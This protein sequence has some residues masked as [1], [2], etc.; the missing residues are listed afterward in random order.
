MNRNCSLPPGSLVWAYCR[1]SGGEDQD[2]QTQRQA[3]LDYI[4]EHDLVLDRLFVD[5]AAPGSTVVGRDAFEEMIHL[6]RTASRRVDGLVLWSFSRFARNLLDA[7]FYKADLRRKGYV[8]ISMTDDLPG[9][10]FDPIMETLYDWMHEQY[11][12]DLSRNVKRTLH[13]LARQGFSARGF[14]P[15]GYRAEKVQIGMKRNGKPRYASRWVPD[16]RWAPIVKRAFEMKADGATTKQI[17]DETRIFNTNNSLT[18]FFR[19]KTYIGVRKCGDIEVPGAHEPLVSRETWD[20]VQARLSAHARWSSSKKWTTGTHPRQRVSSYLLS[21]LIR[22]SECGSAMIGSYDRLR[23]GNKFRFYVCGKRK[24]EGIRGCHTGK[25]RA[26]LI[27]GAAMQHVMDRILTTGYVQTLLEAVNRRMNG[28][29]G[30]IDTEIARVARR[31]SDVNRAIYNLLNS[32]E[33][34][35]SAAARQR[36]TE[37]EAEK[38]QLGGELRSLTARRAES[39]LEVSDEVLSDAL[40]QMRDDLTTGE[41][42]DRRAVLGRFVHRIEAHRERATLWYTF[43]LAM[44][45]LYE[46]PQGG[47]I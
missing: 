32:V 9:G 24:R 46:C 41:L 30:R 38:A 45:P 16:P 14:P 3:V 8:I 25:L 1:D 20:R 2:I 17:L 15:R 22:C 36:L 5:E 26:S 21:G 40:A 47:S 10:D 42:A 7:Q 19:N 13:Q 44:G 31:L 6:S 37:R 34:D 39:R 11:L 12:K 43:P 35:G 27:E 4:K 23:S 29:S 28:E 18:W 33:R